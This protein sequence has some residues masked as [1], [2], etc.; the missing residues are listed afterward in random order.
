MGLKA[1]LVVLVL[2]ALVSFVVMSLWNALMPELFNGPRIGFWQAAGL[3]VL[4]R[5][6]V[7]SWRGG[8]GHWRQ[9]HWERMTPEERARVRARMCGSRAAPE[10]TPAEKSEGKEPA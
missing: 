9:R 3:L 2:A 8:P 4:S 6:L 5:I 7:G 1:L 10:A